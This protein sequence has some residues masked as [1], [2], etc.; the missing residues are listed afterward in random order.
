MSSGVAWY[1]LVHLAMIVTALLPHLL[2]IW[3]P[4]LPLRLLGAQAE[5][6]PLWMPFLTVL[7]S[8]LRRIRSSLSAMDSNMRISSDEVRVWQRASVCV[9]MCLYMYHV[10]CSM[11]RVSCVLCPVCHMQADTEL[12]ELIAKK[13][14]QLIKHVR[15]VNMWGK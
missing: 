5:F 8:R 10:L 11:L 4:G 3:V 2:P 6:A 14:T 15:C 13:M 12:T 9:C 7:V 1:G